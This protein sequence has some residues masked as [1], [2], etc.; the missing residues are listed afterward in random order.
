MIRYCRNSLI[1]LALAAPACAPPPP[2]LSPK[3]VIAFQ[4]TRVVKALDIFRD[5]AVDANAQTPP[6]LDTTTTRKI[7]TWHESAL[8]IVQASSAGWQTTVGVSLDEAVKDVPPA[9]AAKIAPYISLVK[10]ALKEIS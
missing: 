9:M 8:K 5:F 2:T 1:V 10:S 6:I 3:G 4:E 7:V